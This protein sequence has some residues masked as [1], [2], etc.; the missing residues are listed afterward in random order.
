VTGSAE[1]VSQAPARR[2]ERA[3]FLLDF[4]PVKTHKRALACI[5]AAL[6]PCVAC[7]PRAERLQGHREAFESLGATTVLIVQSWLAGDVSGTY[8]GT[9]LDATFFLVEKERTALARRPENVADPDGA[10]LARTA[11]QLSRLVARLA[12]DIAA[13]DG[14]A[15][16]YDVSQI[17]ILPAVPK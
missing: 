6:V 7:T 5:L 1:R 14:A 9:S 16:R 17:P 4:A 8:A 13:S 15:A 3:H 2:H 11:D 10:A 12:R